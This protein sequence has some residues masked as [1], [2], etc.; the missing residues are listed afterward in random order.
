[1]EIVSLNKDISKYGFSTEFDY[2]NKSFNGHQTGVAFCVLNQETGEV[3]ENHIPF[4]D[5]QVKKE[6]LDKIL[7]DT[8]IFKLVEEANIAVNNTI[9]KSD[10]Y[11]LPY[12]VKGHS[13]FTPTV[14][15]DNVDTGDCENYAISLEILFV[16]EK[17]N[18]YSVARIVTNYMS[19]MK[20]IDY[21]FKD[22]ESNI[23]ILNSMGINKVKDE[24]GKDVYHLDFYSQSGTRNDMYFENIDYIK[25]CIVSC[26]LIDINRVQEG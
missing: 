25:D 12:H 18:R 11:M 17:C 19:V 2:V 15:F 21:L 23:K 16:C 5:E 24:N 10:I 8:S 20:C 3:I 7:K 9:V 1:M 22:Y 6:M 26:R 4:E 14:N 13:C